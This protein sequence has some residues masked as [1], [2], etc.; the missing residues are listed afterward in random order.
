MVTKNQIL[1]FLQQ[2]QDTEPKDSIKYYT[3]GAL[4][5]LVNKDIIT[6]A[7]ITAQFPELA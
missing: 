5:I 2:K 3:I 7:D 6:V 1:N 4:R